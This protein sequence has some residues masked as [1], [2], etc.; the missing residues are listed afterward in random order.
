MER[1][2]G[3]W[4]GMLGLAA[5]LG[6][7]GEGAESFKASS[8]GKLVLD[9]DA[10]ATAAIEAGGGHSIEVRYTDECRPACEVQFEET[11]DG[12][13]IRTSFAKTAHS[14][15]SDI[16][17]K[18]KV[19]ARFDIDVSSVGGGISID[20]L[21]GQ[22]TGKTMGGDLKLRHVRGEAEL[23][24]MGGDIELSDSDLDGSLK[25]MG[26]EVTFE[27]VVGDVR[28]SSMGG[29]VRYKNVQSRG[30]RRASPDPDREPIDEVDAESVQ[31]STMGG[32]IEV[33]AAP[34]GA[35]L[36]TMGGDIEVR[37]ARRFVRATTMGGSID[38][39][40]I[41]GWVQATTMGGDIEAHVTGEGGDVVLSSHSGK[42][43]LSVPAGFGMDLDLEIAYTR[44]SAQ[45][46]TITAPGTLKPTETS[47]WDHAHGTPR[48]YIRMSGAVNGG[49]HKVKVRTINGN[50]RVSE[51][52]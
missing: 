36:H 32:E 30:G 34:E 47:E 16:E 49:G 3:L 21:D 27:N 6:L 2:T 12:L 35:D 10:G 18:V 4:V 45:D 52:G 8:G 40:S 20:G 50:L 15:S 41:D 31:I 46:F 1:R 48:K 42:I 17:L 29:N 38:I 5:T 19:P 7:A 14:Q 28:G 9:L 51:G 13:K 43:E 37:D 39:R 23:T 26:G 44:N 33:E 25:T 24:T 22:F 11:G